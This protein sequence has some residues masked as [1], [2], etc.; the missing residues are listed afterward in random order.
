MG[1]FD[2]NDSN[3]LEG[4]KELKK[5]YDDLMEN[6]LNN[7]YSEDLFNESRK[8]KEM[9]KQFDSD[10]VMAI[11]IN[12][13]F[14]NKIENKHREYLN[15]IRE[16]LQVANLLCKE[17]IDVLQKIILSKDNAIYDDAISNFIKKLSE[18]DAKIIDLSGIKINDIKK[19]QD[20]IKQDDDI[21]NFNFDYSSEGQFLRSFTYYF[22]NEIIKKMTMDETI[23][24]F[25]NSEKSCLYISTADF[26]SKYSI[27]INKKNEK[28]VKYLLENYK[29][30]FY[31]PSIMEN[32]ILD[33]TTNKIQEVY[34][35][36]KVEKRY[37]F[38]TITNI[39]Y[40]NLCDYSF[41]IG[42]KK[43]RLSTVCHDYIPYKGFE[44]DYSINYFYLIKD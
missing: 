12:I 30:C 28:L 2:F 44:S 4:I 42:T 37:H 1:R 27:I 3:N 25:V 5:I 6:M 23:I 43:C 29:N 10:A 8:L 22:V 14:L 24:E 31:K 13:D 16:N 18:T 21:I 9:L 39:I 38:N 40:K 34:G 33:M 15:E 35:N 7:G 36:R 17:Y 32:C 20:A 26:E 41:I 11:G 19:A